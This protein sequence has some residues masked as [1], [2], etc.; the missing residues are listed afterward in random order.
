MV[1]QALLGLLAH[2][3]GYGDQSGVGRSTPILLV[4]LAPLCG[5]AFALVLTLGLAP[6]PT[7]TKDRPNCLLARGMVHGDVEQVMGGPRLHTA[8]LVDQGLAGYPREECTDDICF[9]D[10]RKGVAPL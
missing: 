3:I 5:G 10:V 4:L 2:A 8:E 7:A 9:D 1:G 6:V